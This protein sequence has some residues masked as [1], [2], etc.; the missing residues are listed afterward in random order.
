MLIL[1]SDQILT[2]DQIRAVPQRDSSFLYTHYVN[3]VLRECSQMRNVCSVNR[4]RIAIRNPI[5]THRKKRIVI[6]I[7]KVSSIKIVIYM[8]PCEIFDTRNTVKDKYTYY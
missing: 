7:S 8:N 1:T 4:T 3:I 2:N 5:N 6:H